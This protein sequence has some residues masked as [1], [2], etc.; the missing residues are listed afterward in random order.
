MT[1]VILIIKAISLLIPSSSLY[2]RCIERLKAR[3][4]R[5]TAALERRK[6]ESE[7]INLRLNRLESDCSALQM[8][9][10]YWYK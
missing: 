9:L 3:N 5:L 10:R 2:R 1:C 6:G 4:E 8:A 7:Q